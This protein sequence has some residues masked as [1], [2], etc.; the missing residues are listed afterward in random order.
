MPT[1]SLLPRDWR[2]TLTLSLCSAAVERGTRCER[3]RYSTLC[4]EY[5]RER[6]SY[7]PRHPSNLPQRQVARANIFARHAKSAL[8]TSWSRGPWA[9]RISPR[10]HERDRYERKPRENTCK[11]VCGV[12]V[13]QCSLQILLNK[14]TVALLFK[15]TLR[16]VF[17]NALHVLKRTC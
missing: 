10:S 11:A 5:E 13:S 6:P 12:C 7:G 4:D 15:Q 1:S 17:L 16:R 9:R 8:A 14:I 2:R 3:R